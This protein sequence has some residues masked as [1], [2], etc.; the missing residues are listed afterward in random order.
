M[1]PVWL[2]LSMRTLG[3]AFDQSSENEFS[4]NCPKH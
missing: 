2:S 3:L 4:L 1:D